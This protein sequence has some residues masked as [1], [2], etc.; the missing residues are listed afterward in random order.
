MIK[1]IIGQDPERNTGPSLIVRIGRQVHMVMETVRT[2]R[3]TRTE[4]YIWNHNQQID[5]G[6]DIMV[7][8]V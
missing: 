2:P 3:T 5:P 1:N 8:H 6:M 7:N 4:V